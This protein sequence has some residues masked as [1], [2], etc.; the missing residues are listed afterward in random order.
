MSTV[1]TFPIW[2]IF[3]ALGIGLA[4]ARFAYFKPGN[5]TLSIK[6][7]VFLGTMRTIA[8]GAIVLL[9]LSPFLKQIEHY[10]ENPVV[11]V[12]SDNSTSI[13]TGALAD[14]QKKQIPEQINRLF[15]DLSE[16]A[17]TRLFT[18]G[19]GLNDTV[20]F[21]F[22]DG[23]TNL[24]KTFKAIDQ[25][26][27]N[28]NVGAIVLATDGIWN[29]GSDPIYETEKLK[30]PIYTIALGDTTIKADL[31]IKR[32]A[33]NS[34]AFVGNAF[35]VE[36][37]VQANKLMGQQITATLLEINA[38]GTS[39]KIAQ[40]QA[41]IDKIAQFFTFS[42]SVSALKPG[43]LTYKVVLSN[44]PNEITYS[45]NSQLFAIDIIDNK[46][47]VLI[48]AASPHPDIS[49][50]KNYLETSKQI[51]VEVAFAG[52]S[53]P[54][55]KGYD[56][57][58]FHQLPSTK[59]N[60]L[61]WVEQCKANKIGM[62]FIVGKQ[63]QLSLLN[64][65]QSLAVFTLRA[66]NQFNKALPSIN[67]GFTNF[68][69]AEKLPQLIKDL[70][71]LETP[72]ADI[73]PSLQAQVVMNQQIGNVVTTNPLIF[74]GNQQGQRIGVI[75]GEGIWRWR[76]AEYQAESNFET[77]FD[78]FSKL[79][80]YLS[81]RA[82]KRNFRAYPAQP[83]FNENEKINFIAEL[84]DD[85]FEP[86]IKADINLKITNS[87]GK[88]FQYT[89]LPD[90]ERFQAL[91]GRLPAGNYQYEAYTTFNQLP[92]SQKGRFQV[93]KIDLEGQETKANHDLLNQMATS[94]GGNMYYLGNLNNLTKEI[95]ERD[96]LKPTKYEQVILQPLINISWLLALILLLLSI[97][98]FVRKYFGS[99]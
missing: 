70:P 35:P 89:F 77:T 71:P 3:L 55:I 75:A 61:N 87:E 9:F 90:V 33:V 79:T 8:V 78:F 53:S 56:L 49:A 7:R 23:I 15:Q 47:K 44:L 88:T 50:L 45:N 85:A 28:R 94:S 98:W 84:Y 68:R 72:F 24:S 52:N 76:I 83:T 19:D 21:D 22:S 10:F 32:L 82:D 58:I 81:L 37:Q 73:K 18:F 60:I 6:L 54:Q 30:A 20:S 57:V 36:L 66:A 95:L 34:I 40:Q 96:D 67:A 91:V 46:S 17:D 1:A 74:I 48:M 39:Q 41:R 14:D 11:I 2:Y 26:F 12:L 99:Y 80:Q 25:R 5:P 63:T 29:A 42:F 62:L 4:F 64:Q 51:T 27:G 13:V 31:A 43:N 16:K 93:L 69:F 97:E 38:D 92:L 65:M 59:H 86:V